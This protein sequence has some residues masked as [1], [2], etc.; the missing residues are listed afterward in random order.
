ML[1]KNQARRQENLPRAQHELEI[2]KRLKHQIK[3]ERLRPQKVKKDTNRQLEGLLVLPIIIQGIKFYFERTDMRLNLVKDYF[4]VA[5]CLWNKS[6]CSICQKLPTCSYTKMNSIHLPQLKPLKLNCVN[7]WNKSRNKVSE[8][9][10]EYIKHLVK[11]R[12][13]HQVYP[14]TYRRL[15]SHKTSSP[16]RDL[17][18]SSVIS[19][20]LLR[21]LISQEFHFSQLLIDQI[22][23]QATLSIS[24]Y[25]KVL[26]SVQEMTR[27]QRNLWLTSKPCNCSM[28]K[29]ASW[30]K[31]TKKLCKRLEP[32]VKLVYQAT[33]GTVRLKWSKRS[34][35]EDKQQYHRSQKR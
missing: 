13:R 27:L 35:Q 6:K 31:R 14:C 2:Y 12:W 16:I 34:K 18:H 9:C 23:E 11:T 25:L 32:S 28:T 21:V 15:S 19:M 7:S 30:P 4:Q 1:H 5:Q 8:A 24:L 22:R 26:P 29:L 17:K 3:M 20:R 10:C 33:R